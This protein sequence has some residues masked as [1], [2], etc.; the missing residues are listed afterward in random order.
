MGDGV[1]GYESLLICK[2]LKE[3]SLHKV[4]NFLHMGDGVSG[5]ESLLIYKSLTF[6]WVMG[7][8]G[9]NH[10]LFTRA[11]GRTSFIRLMRFVDRNVSRLPFHECTNPR[12]NT[13]RQP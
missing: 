7:Y 11:S 4:D 8:L 1:S 3:N 9:M 5:Y 6:I 12:E 10:C 13:A 2:S